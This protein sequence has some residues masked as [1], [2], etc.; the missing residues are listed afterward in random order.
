MGLKLKEIT[1]ETEFDSVSSMTPVW[2]S[3]AD[4]V[5]DGITDN[6]G[7]SIILHTTEAVL[8]LI[9]QAGNLFLSG[10]MNVLITISAALKPV[11]KWGQTCLF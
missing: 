3:V 6:N 10:A 2:Q 4:T 7:V 8:L 5:C 9:F 11:H 1:F